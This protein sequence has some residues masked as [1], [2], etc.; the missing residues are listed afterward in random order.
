MELFF[1]GLVIWTMCGCAS[2]V[3]SSNKGQGGCAGFA[4]GFLLGPLGLIIVA[5]LPPTDRALVR[6]AQLTSQA[7]IGAQ[8][9]CP[10]CRSFVP[11][12]ATVCRFCQRDLT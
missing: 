3:I 2:A 6:K 5:C 9:T 8:K 4:V 11:A 1:L 7:E 10:Y 12:A